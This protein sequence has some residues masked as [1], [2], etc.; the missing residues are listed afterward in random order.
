MNGQALLVADLG[1]IVGAVV[2]IIIAGVS[3]LA[4][5]LN[6]KQQQ[7]RPQD[8][9]QPGG[10]LGPQAQHPQAPRPQA[11][12][13]EIGDFLRRAAQ[14]R[15]GQQPA[16]GQ[17]PRQVQPQFGPRPQQVQPQ[18]QPRPQQVRPQPRPALAQP[19]AQAQVVEPERPPVGEGLSDLVR[20][21]VDTEAFT[22]RASQLG[23][24]AR[25][26]SRE[27]EER[28]HETFDH[29]LGLLEKK[30]TGKK[31]TKKPAP[32]SVALPPTSAAGFAALLHD[33]D[34]LRHAVILSEILQRP[35]HRW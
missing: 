16:G 8:P 6:N 22:R 15:G 30:V 27:A 2:F 17:A 10:A 28:L 20:K 7:Q 5:F 29:D 13:D 32:A 21:D 35:E 18:L 9:R 33:A 26:A 23:Q 31:K 12:D 11:L 19:V 24:T 4:Q 3:I 34:S 1:E 25:L 14:N